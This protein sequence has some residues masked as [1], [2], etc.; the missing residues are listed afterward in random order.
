[1]RGKNALEICLRKDFHSC[2]V[3]VTPLSKYAMAKYGLESEVTLCP[4]AVRSVEAVV[5][6]VQFPVAMPSHN[7]IILHWALSLSREA[8]S[9]NPQPASTTGHQ[10]NSEQNNIKQIIANQ[11]NTEQ[12]TTLI[13]EHNN[14]MCAGQY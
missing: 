2:D 14:H 10:I 7:P 9:H 12:V 13:N 1:M 8:P 4:A 5:G 11:S 6:A 3:C